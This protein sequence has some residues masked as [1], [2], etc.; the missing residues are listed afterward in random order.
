MPSFL[1]FSSLPTAKPPLPAF[2]AAAFFVFLLAAP[3]AFA[4]GGANL[5]ADVGGFRVALDQNDDILVPNTETGFTVFLLDPKTNQPLPNVPAWIRISRSNDVLMASGQFLTSAAGGIPI[6]FRFPSEA[7][8]EVAATFKVNGKDISAKFPLT[9]GQPD[10]VKGPWEDPA[11]LPGLIAGLL[12][13]A[14]GV[15]L[16]PMVFKREKVR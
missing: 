8:Y 13:L 4:H 5:V 11:A 16:S 14:L 10:R 12:G 9:V 15:V 3:L 1:S 7:Q 2:I 6:S